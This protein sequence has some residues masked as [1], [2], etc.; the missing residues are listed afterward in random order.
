MLKIIRKW[1]ITKIDN[2][3]LDKITPNDNTN[4][5][6]IRG[7]RSVKDF[8]GIIDRDRNWRNIDKKTPTVYKDNVIKFPITSNVEIINPIPPKDIA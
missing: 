8:M 7:D 6:I 4:C 2:S 1:I 5:I 3:D